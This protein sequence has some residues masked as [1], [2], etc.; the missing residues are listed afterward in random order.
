MRDE[1]GGAEGEA[2]AEGPRDSRAR[3]ENWMEYSLSYGQAVGAP[4]T[5][6]SPELQGR[7]NVSL[8]NVPITPLDS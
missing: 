4:T 5:Q 6:I 7:I 3:A 2:G 1:R 8:I